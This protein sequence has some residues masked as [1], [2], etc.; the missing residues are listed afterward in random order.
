[1]R[2]LF[3]GKKISI[4]VKFAVHIT[5]SV[6]IS[7][8]LIC[9]SNRIQIIINLFKLLS[10]RRF[11]IHANPENLAFCMISSTNHC[12]PNIQYL[13]PTNYTLLTKTQVKQ[14]HRNEEIISHRMICSYTCSTH[15]SEEKKRKK[16]VFSQHSVYF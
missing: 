10:S 11:L 9:Q 16:N 7:G 5:A 13:Y 2:K 1:M 8:I 4:R 15:S 14:R 3:A 6:E 12:F